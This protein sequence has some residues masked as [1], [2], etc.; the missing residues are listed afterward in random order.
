[1]NANIETGFAI[2]SKSTS[3]SYVV[4]NLDGSIHKTNIWAHQE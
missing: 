4:Y 2:F 3:W 1:M